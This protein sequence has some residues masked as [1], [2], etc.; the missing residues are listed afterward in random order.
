MSP[1]LRRSISTIAG[2][3]IFFVMVIATG[4]ADDPILGPEG[5]SDDGGGSYGVIKQF[6]PGDTAQ[7]SPNPEQF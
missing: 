4:C 7:T 6:A 5:P 3:I 1:L 2:V